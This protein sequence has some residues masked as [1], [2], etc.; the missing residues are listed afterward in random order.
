MKLDYYCTLRDFNE[1]SKIRSEE[2][3]KKISKRKNELKSSKKNI[4]PLE[5]KD[6]L[7][8]IRQYTF[9]KGESKIQYTEDCPECD[10]G[11]EFILDST[12]LQYD[13]PDPEVMQ[14]YDQD[15]C[16][17]RIDPAEYDVNGEPFTLYLP[18]LEKDANIKA[19]IIDRL[20][21]NK[22]VDNV[23]IKFLPWMAH[24]I[25]KDTTIAARQ[26]KEF[27]LKFKSMDADMFSFMNDVINNIMVTPSTKLMSKCPT[28]GEEVSTNI[29]F[30]NGVS[31]LFN[32][33]RPGK[34]FGKK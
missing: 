26:I 14:Y 21:N 3:N 34:K 12:T 10:N 30:P 6:I 24:K 33:K 23:F 7:L 9:V 15:E 16:T 11:V 5:T 13:L 20:Q 32:I 31:E 19:W 17:W 27:E 4:K 8:L 18:T 22:K 1:E 25:S 28:C 2:I 29:R